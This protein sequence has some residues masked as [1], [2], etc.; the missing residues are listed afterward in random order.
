MKTLIAYYD[1]TDYSPKRT[2]DGDNHN[3][4]V[5]TRKSKRSRYTSIDNC[6]IKHPVTRDASTYRD[7]QRVYFVNDGA[8]LNVYDTDDDTDDD[9]DDDGV[10]YLGITR[11]NPHLE[12]QD[13]SSRDTEITEE[14]EEINQDVV[15]T[16]EDMEILNTFQNNFNFDYVEG[17]VCCIC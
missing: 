5:A 13:N 1:D 4:D 12:E 2:L 16:A 7:N 8:E 9:A 15:E 14:A 3:S 11:V 17:G 10:I 6:N